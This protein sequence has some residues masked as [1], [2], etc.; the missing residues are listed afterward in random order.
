MLDGIGSFFAGGFPTSGGVSY[1]K[2]ARTAAP[3]PRQAQTELPG[4]NADEADGESFGVDVLIRKLLRCLHFSCRA[5]WNAAA[6]LCT[7][8]AGASAYITVMKPVSTS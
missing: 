6:I 3:N 1:F 5:E 2:Q 4:T 7:P 8:R